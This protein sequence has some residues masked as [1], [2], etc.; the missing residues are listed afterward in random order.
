MTPKQL[1]AGAAKSRQVAGAMATKAKALDGHAM[2]G[3]QMVGLS[4]MADLFSGV[5]VVMEAMAKAD[6][7]K[8]TVDG[9]EAA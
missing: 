9:E 5:A 6:E 3:D 2:L 4:L 1:E 8:P 7:E